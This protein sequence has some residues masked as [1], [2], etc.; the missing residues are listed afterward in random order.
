MALLK[1]AEER[2]LPLGTL[3]IF[4]RLE[5][6]KWK[7]FIAGVCW[8]AQWETH[9][10]IEWYRF[11]FPDDSVYGANERSVSLLIGHDEETFSKTIA[12]IFRRTYR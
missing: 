3:E 10:P 2:K 1:E 4:T 7:T 11:V 12:V 9:Q 5:W 8:Q 6:K